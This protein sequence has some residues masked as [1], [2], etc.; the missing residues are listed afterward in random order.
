MFQQ[1]SPYVYFHKD[2]FIVVFSDFRL[3]NPKLFPAH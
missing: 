2:F 3:S 1:K